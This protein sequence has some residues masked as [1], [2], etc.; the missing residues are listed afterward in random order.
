MV[1]RLVERSLA[2]RLYGTKELTEL[3]GNKKIF[4]FQLMSI[5]TL[6]GAGIL[7]FLIELV[8]PSFFDYPYLWHL[9]Q[10]NDIMT[11]WPLLA[12]AALMAYLSSV[13]LKSTNLDEEILAWSSLTSILAGIWE[14]IGYR[15]LFICLAMV[16]I[17]IANFLLNSVI[18]FVVGG[19]V[20]VFGLYLT[21]EKSRILGII[22][23][24]GGILLVWL[25]WGANPIYLWYDYVVVPVVNVVTLWQFNHVFYN[26]YPPLFLFGMIT[27]NAWFRDGHK[28]QGPIGIVN[29]WIVGFVMMSAMLNHGLLTAICIHAVYDLEFSFIH[30]VFRKIDWM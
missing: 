13:K 25:C 20:V 14:E 22:T 6:A 27:A 12:Y 7:V 5:S 24:L 2:K 29:S 30:Y 8:F 28:Y 18:C 19:V 3:E 15:W 11:Y 1:K 16:G 26:G 10:L 23:I 21:S 9:P 17:T 4:L